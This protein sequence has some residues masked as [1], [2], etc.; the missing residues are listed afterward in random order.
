VKTDPFTDAFYFL[1][2]NTPDH[3]ALGALQYPFVALFAA[4]LIGSVVIAVSAWRRDPA[5]R[6]LGALC[7]WVFRVLMGGMWFQGA[8]WKMPLPVSGGL[9]YWTGQMV[10][11]A[12]FPFYSQLIRGLIQPNMTIFDPIVLAAELGLA[13]SFMLGVFVR[14]IATL[15]VLY[16]LGLW[17]GLYRHPAEW[18]WEYMFIV[19]VQGQFAV[20]QA[21]RSLGIDALRRPLWIRT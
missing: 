18:P 10:E 3:R 5:Q 13:V 1:L 11:H 12:A 7:T 19:I 20:N 16:A 9:Q 2:G 15:G 14:P 8:L 21:G 4:L 17:I 6:T